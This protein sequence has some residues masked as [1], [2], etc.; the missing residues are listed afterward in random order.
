MNELLQPYFERQLIE[1]HRQ[2]GYWIEVFGIN[3]GSKPDI[4]GYGLNLGE[5]YFE[6][7]RR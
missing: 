5:V 4:V 3:N 1:D 2:D 6:R 7:S